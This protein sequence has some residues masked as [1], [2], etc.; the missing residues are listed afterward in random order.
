MLFSV[1]VLHVAERAKDPT[2]GTWFPEI[3]LSFPILLFQSQEEQCFQ[4]R[5]G[6]EGKVRK[7]KDRQGKRAGGLP[8]ASRV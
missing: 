5:K 7:R 4:E 6:Q 3:C 2:P 8:E 1:D